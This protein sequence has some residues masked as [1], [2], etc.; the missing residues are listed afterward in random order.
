MEWKSVFWLF[1]FLMSVVVCHGEGPMKTCVSHFPHT[2]IDV[3]KE[4]AFVLLP[5][6]FFHHG[7]FR[8]G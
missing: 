5:L 1:E 4:L 2:E 3:C 8:L 6:L 7:S